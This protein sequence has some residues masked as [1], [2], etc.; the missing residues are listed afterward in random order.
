VLCFQLAPEARDTGSHFNVRSLMFDA[1]ALMD[2]EGD[3][4]GRRR[5]L[6]DTYEL[7]ARELAGAREVVRH[8]TNEPGVHLFE[9]QGR[10][11]VLVAW[12]RGTEAAQ[13]SWPWT[14]PRQPRAVNALGEEVPV[15][16]QDGSIVIPVSATPVFV[17]P[18]R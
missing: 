4:I 14:S 9:V 10:G 3:T 11:S 15:R 7:M 6:A 12:R 17:R 5:P 18:D 8:D 2:Y 1:F 13:I 16:L